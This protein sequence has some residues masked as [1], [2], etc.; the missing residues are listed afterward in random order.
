M[1]EP[2]KGSK[3]QKI[4]LKVSIYFLV[5]ICCLFAG[6]I[7]PAQ[8]SEPWRKDWQKFGE[9]VAPYARS[10]A[11]ELHGNFREFNRI[12]SKRVEWAGTLRAFHD[13]GVAKFLTLEMQPVRIL[14]PDGSAV[15]IK[16]LAISC[17]SEKSGCEGW[18]AE[19]IGKEVIFRTELINRT[20]GNQPVVMLEDTA[21][22]AR[23][24]GIKTY[25]AVLIKVVSK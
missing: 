9:A 8:E 1:C 4:L 12:F 23:T 16:E 10:G 22:G 18:S 13:N 20:R 14:L 3:M 24:I 2:V 11:L 15:E 21:E 19:L 17:T 6:R 25:G 7:S 5:A